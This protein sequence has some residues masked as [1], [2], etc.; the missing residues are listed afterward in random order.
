VDI[1]VGTVSMNGSYLGALRNDTNKTLEFNKDAGKFVLYDL[2]AD[3]ITGSLYVN[4]SV[5][6]LVYANSEAQ[7]L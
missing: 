2:T 3:I 1:K 5:S 7:Q 6:N 4:G